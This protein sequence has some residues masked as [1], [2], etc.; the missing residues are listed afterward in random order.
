MAPAEFAD[1]DL[2]NAEVQLADLVKGPDPQWGR[3][4][5]PGG[6]PYGSEETEV[7]QDLAGLRARLANVTLPA[8]LGPASSALKAYVRSRLAAEPAVTATEA[9]SDAANYGVGDVA[10][11]AAMILDADPRAGE[12]GGATPE[13]QLTAT[14][15][16]PVD[17]EPG[18]AT[19]RLDGAT[20]Q[21]FDYREE[22]L[23][24]AATMPCLGEEE[25]RPERRQCL[26]KSVAAALLMQDR[27]PPS[28][29]A[30]DHK[31]AELR[32]ELAAKAW[33]TARAL[34]PAPDRVTASEA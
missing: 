6:R 4:V 27:E 30:V 9:L 10:E 14:S 22:I 28:Q 12:L 25:P 15:G 26:L 3:N 33:D 17:G 16:P 5:H 18:R 34:G 20:W 31:A 23:P 13:V 24:T 32:G 2:T 1:L 19:M 21:V 11:E 29:A 8:A 7:P